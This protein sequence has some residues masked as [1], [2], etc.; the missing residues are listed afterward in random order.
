MKLTIRLGIVALSIGVLWTLNFLGVAFPQINEAWAHNDPPDVDPVMVGNQ[1]CS[2]SGANLQL[3]A[4]R[5]GV[6]IP[7]G[8]T[9]FKGETI[10]Y[11]LRMFDPPG[12]GCA[13]EAGD[14]TITSPDG[15]LLVT[16][17]PPAI[18]CIG[19]TTSVG[20]TVGALDCGSAGTFDNGELGA[21]IS[22]PK[23][24]EVDC[25]DTFGSP[26]AGNVRALATYSSED[27]HINLDD[28]GAVDVS[29]TLTNP[30]TG[31]MI[32]WEKRQLI[33]AAGS[34]PL[35][36][37]ATFSISPDPA[38][39]VGGP[40]PVTDCIVPVP[41]PNCDAKLDKDP[42]AGQFKLVDVFIGSDPGTMYTII[43]TAAPNGCTPDADTTRV[44]TVSSAAPNQVIGSA[45][46]N[47]P[48]VDNDAP[49]TDYHNTCL[50]MIEWEKRDGTGAATPH[51]LQTGATFSIGTSVG[52]NHPITGA[53][54]TPLIV[55]VDCTSGPC[56]AGAGLDQDADA[57]QYKINDVIPGTYIITETAAPS[58][59]TIG[60]P[61]TR[62]VTVVAG[63]SV[64]PGGLP[65]GTDQ[66]PPTGD[67]HNTC[68]GPTTIVT[69][70]SSTGQ[71]PPGTS[72]TDTA[73]VTGSGIIPAQTLSGTLTFQLCGP[74]PSPST[75][76]NCIAAG[77]VP[78]TPT[79]AGECKGT[80]PAQ[81]PTDLGHYCWTVTFTPD[82]SSPYLGSSETDPV[83]NE[84]FQVHVETP[85]M[86]GGGRVNCDP[87][88]SSTVCNPVNGLAT[89]AAN[90]KNDSPAFKVTH[91]FE[92]H[93][94]TTQTPNNLEVNW[95][96]N[97]FHL[98]KLTKVT[99]IDNENIAPHPPKSPPSTNID[100]YIGEGKGR[101]NGVCGATA[102]WIFTDAGEPGKNDKIFKLVIKN[103]LGATVLSINAGATLDANDPVVGGLNLEVGNHQFHQHNKDHPHPNLKTNPCPGLNS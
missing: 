51:P 89:I 72:V 54:G 90:G 81:S 77:T 87:S 86:T 7:G 80:S 2:G 41:D 12:P 65:L 34:H 94:T 37:G 82:P 8:G 20:D 45:L 10:Q 40:V 49:E 91:G 44:V 93:C 18:P 78:C 26:P 71:V 36:G 11:E 92:L 66:E 4:R 30:C 83:A 23:N 62:T 43:E 5:G 57:G 64:A 21:F 52:N 100:V 19:G 102:E 84:C 61:A 97:K 27:V 31:G 47:P 76:A 88:A 67:F 28:T 103:A 1:P 39:G 58:G 29:T 46:G 33:G 68:K 73:T 70:S 79:V 101:Y 38:T 6:D 59:C 53:A 17:P 74:N 13:N 96:G 22:N 56:A 60:T 75:S 25:T 55:S 63:A 99:C 42:D 48:G 85:F 9:V 24:Y 14:I 50:G 98:E 32:E 16:N 15:V 95:N 35:L 69:A 3:V